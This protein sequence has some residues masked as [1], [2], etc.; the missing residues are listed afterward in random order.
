MY[1]DRFDDAVS[2]FSLAFQRDPRSQFAINIAAAELQRGDCEKAKLYLL[3][4]R[5][6]WPNENVDK[7]KLL[8]EKVEKCR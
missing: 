2:Y 4:H 6:T 7:V 8:F 3:Y 5:K 1:A